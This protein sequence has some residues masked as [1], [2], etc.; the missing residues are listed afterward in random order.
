MSIRT[1]SVVLTATLWDM[2]RSVATVTVLLGALPIN[3]AAVIANA[4]WENAPSPPSA[5]APAPY[6][7]RLDR[8]AC[9]F[10]RPR[11]PVYKAQEKLRSIM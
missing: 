11:R 5:Y 10:A 8:V 2:E 6:V 3:V 1:T 4:G 7:R 9:G